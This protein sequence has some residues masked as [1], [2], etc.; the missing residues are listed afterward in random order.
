MK[1]LITIGVV[2]MLVTLA[3]YGIVGYV[4]AHF[5]SKF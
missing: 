1:R 2:A 4:I 3:F 5:I